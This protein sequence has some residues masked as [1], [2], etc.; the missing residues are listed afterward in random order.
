MSYKN[1]GVTFEEAIRISESTPDYDLGLYGGSVKS[2]EVVNGVEVYEYELHTHDKSCNC[3]GK[4][5]AKRDIKVNS[6]YIDTPNEV[7]GRNRVVNCT[8]WI[9]KCGNCG[10]TLI[11]DLHFFDL[12]FNV[13][14]RVIDYIYMNLD[15]LSIQEASDY[16][17]L[18]F[19][20]VAEIVFHYY[21]KELLDAHKNSRN[22]I[23]FQ[24]NNDL[25]D[26][27]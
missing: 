18:P 8:H 24:K 26:A 11:N 7:T 5:Q 20:E 21:N 19:D 27:C 13:T 22:S 3:C 16:I 12:R 23:W 25:I 17:G 14:K 9:N 10:M 2:M 6:R 15:K 1:N 4:R